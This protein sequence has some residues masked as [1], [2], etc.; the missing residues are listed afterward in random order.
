MKAGFGHRLVNQILGNFLFRQHRRDHG[1]IA[2]RALQRTHQRAPPLGRKIADVAGHGIVDHQRQIGLRGLE[3]CNRLR[4]DG[5]VHGES[6]IVG[7]IHRSRFNLG[8]KSISLLERLHL[9]RIDRIDH[10]VE[11]IPQ[12][13]LGPQV[14][15]AGQHQVHGAIEVCLGGL[16]FARV[17]IRHTALISHFD[18]VDQGL[19]LG[20]GGRD[21]GS[22]GCVA[23]GR[24]RVRRA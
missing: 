9:Q 24:P 16:Q 23:P 6:D 13:G 2:A 4:L 19:Y 12:L 7:D 3:F 21:G 14:E 18:C 17:V 15:I 22:C 11:L 5:R 8:R 20:A 10:A 1:M